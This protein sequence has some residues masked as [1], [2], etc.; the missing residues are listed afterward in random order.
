MDN[1]YT[2]IN[3]TPDFEAKVQQFTE[4][5]QTPE[6]V[7]YTANKAEE[8]IFGNLSES[9]TDVPFRNPNEKMESLLEEQLKQYEST[10]KELHKQLEDTQL[11]LKQLNDKE[12]YNNLY[13]K[14]LKADLQ[15]ESLKRELAENKLSSKDWKT[16]V[17][18][19]LTAVIVLLIEHWKDL[20]NFILSLT[21][22][23]Q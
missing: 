14:E 17:I 5:M 9:L 2:P 10:N 8:Q 4:L 11:Q 6:M 13:I 3:L 22:L 16:I 1:N 23:Q 18:S 12:S 21:E 15:M 20:Y 19:F 7:N